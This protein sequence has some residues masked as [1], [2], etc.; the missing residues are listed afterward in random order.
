MNLTKQQFEQ[1]VN[2]RFWIYHAGAG[3]SA[4][5]LVEVKTGLSPAQYEAFSLIFRGDSEQLHAQ[6][7]YAVEH[8]GLG[9][10]DLFLVP[11]GR[12][13]NGFMYE[14]VFNRP[15]NGQD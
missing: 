5:E 7:T 11:V 1:N 14:A 2:T 8:D 6:R 4:V 3:R 13:P 12:E 10:F 15:R 9:M